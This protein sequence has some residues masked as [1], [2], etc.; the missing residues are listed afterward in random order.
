LV[1]SV[2]A[3]L[4]L[5][6]ALDVVGL[7]SS[8]RVRADVTHNK[9][10]DWPRPRRPP[11]ATTSTPLLRTHDRLMTSSDP[12]MGPADASSSTAATS[13]TS[14]LLK[15]LLDT[16]NEIRSRAEVS[17]GEV[18]IGAVRACDGIANLLAISSEFV[19]FCFNTTFWYSFLTSCS[20]Y[21]TS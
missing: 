17:Q 3:A 12:N 1:V 2:A 21:K 15:A 19:S 14:Q 7:A 13:S 6:S 11:T 5:A 4:A 18:L 20:F 16:Q 9:R 8:C 10:H